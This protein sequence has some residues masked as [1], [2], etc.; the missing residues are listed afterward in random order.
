MKLLYLLKDNFDKHKLKFGGWCKN[1]SRI[2]QKMY[3]KTT[4]I[5]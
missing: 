3:L 5:M 1:F 2:K 4:P